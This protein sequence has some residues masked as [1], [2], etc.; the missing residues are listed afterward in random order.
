MVV[1]PSVTYILDIPTA[2][3]KISHFVVTGFIT[4]DQRLREP[5]SVSV[6]T[7]DEQPRPETENGDE[8]ELSRMSFGDHLDELRVRLLKALGV[9]L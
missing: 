7:A 3:L 5:G 4:A 9:R 6:M 8:E 2:T 1:S